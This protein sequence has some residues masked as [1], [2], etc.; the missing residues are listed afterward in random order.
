MLDPIALMGSLGGWRWF[1]LRP[2]FLM[3]GTGVPGTESR[4]LGT[5]GIC[6]ILDE[7]LR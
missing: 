7:D 4:A 6:W 2:W 3:M 1:W 5:V